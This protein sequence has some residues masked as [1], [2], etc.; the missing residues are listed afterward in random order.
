MGCKG[1]KEAKDDK[2]IKY[3]FARLNLLSLDDFFNKASDLLKS[4]EDIRSGLDDNRERGAELTGTH[5]LKETKYVDVVQVL[6]WTLSAENGGKIKD[7]EIDVSSETPFIKLDGRKCTRDTYDIYETFSGYVKTVMDGPKTVQDV[8]DQ[9]QA[10]ADKMPTVTQD[11]KA[12][13]QNS[14]MGFKDKAESIAKLGK[15]TAKLPKE[16]AKCKNLKQTLEQAKTD[17]QELLPKLKELLQ[18][19]DEVGAKAS[20]DGLKK[21]PEI[22]DKYHTGARKEGGDKKEEKKEKKEDKKEEKKEEKEHKEERE[23]KEEK[24]HKE[25][26][27]HKEEKAEEAH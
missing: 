24:E 15:N 23:H 7:T 3:D 27:E 14:S 13:I 8:V 21:A 17:L 4:A 26:Q 22:F 6:F 11:G 10:L 12:E 1:S 18:N 9:L 5:N 20:G 2:E 25:E 16:L 19:A